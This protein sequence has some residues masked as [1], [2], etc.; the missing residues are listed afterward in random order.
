MILW[1]M[2]ASVMEGGKR[3]KRSHGPWLWCLLGDPVVGGG[4]GGLNGGG[5][6][7]E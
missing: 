5:G 2:L 7:I 6:W 4:G 1:C 3:E